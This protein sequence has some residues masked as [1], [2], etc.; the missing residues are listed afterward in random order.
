[1]TC[2]LSLQIGRLCPFCGDTSS[3]SDQLN[4][5]LDLV[6]DD[7][8]TELGK[9]IV[10]NKVRGRVQVR[11]LVFVVRGRFSG[12]ILFNFG[13]QIFWRN[14]RYLR[15]LSPAQF[16]RMCKAYANDFTEGELRRFGLNLLKLVG[17]AVEND[18]AK[19]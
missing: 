9:P 19:R 4:S 10:G 11:S 8:V 12:L 6:H 15:R 13:P 16:D 14:K 5:H 18:T 3:N 2:V 7:L 1:M 17:A